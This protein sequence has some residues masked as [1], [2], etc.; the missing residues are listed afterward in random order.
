MAGNSPTEPSHDGQLSPDEQLA[1]RLARLY[2]DLQETDDLLDVWSKLS[3]AAGSVTTDTIDSARR[4]CVAMAIVA[5]CRA[6]VRS[7]SEN[8]AV[9]RIKLKVLPIGKE[10]WAREIH[11][12]ALK[13]RNKLIA[14]S[15]WEFHHTTLLRGGPDQIG[16][17][18][19]YSLPTVEPK[20]NVAKF[21]KLAKIMLEQSQL[22]RA[23]LDRKVL[24][25][26]AGRL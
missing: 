24:M 23:D 10:P 18:R 15:D 22:M 12:A 9:A 25:A 3:R 20:I 13:L 2:Q 4:A 5:Y 6:F 26:E 17:A 14:H 11:L 16:V 1:N 19:T 8:L 7:N 21:H